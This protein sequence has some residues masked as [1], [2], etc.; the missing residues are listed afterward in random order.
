M[1]GHD[2]Q[3]VNLV[4][5][6][7]DTT[8]PRF[9]PAF[10]VPARLDMA[11][12][13]YESQEIYDLKETLD[14]HRRVGKYVDFTTDL[15]KCSWEDVHQE[16]AKAQ[17][18][19]ARNEK[20]GKR[21]HTKVWRGIG[22]TAS[23]L[24]PGLS[25]LPDE[26]CLLHGGLALVF[27]LA[28]H[29]EMNRLRIL[30]A[31]EM[32]PNIIEMARNK[33]E[34]FPLDAKNPKSVK[35]HK[36]VHELRT[37]LLRALPALIQ[38][39]V[40]SS[41]F[42]NWCKGPFGGYKIDN[43][44]EEVK[45]RAEAVQI[46]NDSLIDEV[47]VDNYAATVSIQLQLDELFRMQQEMLMSV[48][49]NNSKTHLLNFFMEQ[50]SMNSGP[51]GFLTGRDQ[52]DMSEVGT[53][54]PGYT[55]E[56]LL[57]IM[58]VN[59]LRI[60]KDSAVVGRRGPTFSAEDNERAAHMVMVPQIRALMSNTGP[61]IVAVDGHFDRSQI[62]KISPLSYMCSM[63]SQAMRQQSLENVA[64][65]PTSLQSAGGSPRKVVLEYYCSLHTTEEDDLYGPQ[66]LMRCL[67]AQ[68]I[69]F[70]LANGWLGQDEAVYLPYLWNVEEDM[71]LQRR[72]EAVCRLFTALTRHVPQ[73]VPVFCFVDCWS[74]YER[75]DLW[76]TDYEVVIAT[77]REATNQSGGESGGNLRLL[78]TSP[79]ISRWLVD[80]L[81]EDQRVSLRHRGGRGGH[82]RGAGRGSL[83]SVARAATLPHANVGF[84]MDFSLD[85]NGQLAEGGHDRTPSTGPLLFSSL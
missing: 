7:I 16:L 79:T 20:A 37:T 9:H 74:A 17:A 47:I 68:L 19:A 26:L 3:N 59:H 55:P 57:R 23:I 64:S 46:C 24:A 44:L 51:L 42:T 34:L 60:A 32:V 52:A 45:T 39:L 38:K 63:L 58:D 1:N 75:E 48:H 40:P 14:F 8:A 22:N 49:A 28:R 30:G 11:T 27:S 36:N 5:N 81:P 67:V 50:I 70:L 85:S 15:T 31:F 56:D 13:Q 4:T 53:A 71:L 78:L 84:G 83:V 72:L 80:L 10:G 73:G 82:W 33:A 54:L 69:L 21:L 66:G 65:T 77:L 29:S 35:L 2:Q 43:L 6:F 41:S 61:S 76:R 18:A 62:G 12:M 25:A